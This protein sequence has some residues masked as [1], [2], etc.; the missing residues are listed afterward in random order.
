MDTS[1]EGGK[2]Q[3]PLGNLK[4][5][6]QPTL[7]PRH[8]EKNLGVLAA[9]APL[10]AAAAAAAAARQDK[11]PKLIPKIGGLGKCSTLRA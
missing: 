2:S 5:R 10:R 9:M 1:E 6:G 7:T 8:S 11:P 4:R 3:S